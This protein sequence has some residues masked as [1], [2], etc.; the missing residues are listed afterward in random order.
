MGGQ[1]IGR[2]KA[3]IGNEGDLETKIWEMRDGIKMEQGNTEEEL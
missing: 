1:K 3:R 2:L